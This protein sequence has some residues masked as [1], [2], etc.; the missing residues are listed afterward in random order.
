[1][2]E[3]SSSPAD[4]TYWDNPEAAQFGPETYSPV[5]SP[6]SYDTPYDPLLTLAIVDPAKAMHHFNTMSFDTLNATI[7]AHLWSTGH[8][9]DIALFYL[10][11]KVEIQ[12]VHQLG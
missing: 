8:V 5:S 2:S 11:R 6:L 4:L 9:P 1:M 3:T 12:S 10:F 7:N